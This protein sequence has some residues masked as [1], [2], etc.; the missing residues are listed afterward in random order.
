MEDDSKKTTIGSRE[1]RITAIPEG[2]EISTLDDDGNRKQTI[3]F[4]GEKITIKT[5]VV[6]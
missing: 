1:V 4:D 3:A 5:D 6:D 2:V